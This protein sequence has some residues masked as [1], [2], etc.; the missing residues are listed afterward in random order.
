MVALMSCLYQCRIYGGLMALTLEE[1]KDRLKQLDEVILV[2]VLQLE[3]G[4]IVYRF[5]DLIEKNFHDL[6][7]QLE[8]PYSYD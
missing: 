8:E 5:E 7:M 4:D 3:S 6:E 2:D 1:L